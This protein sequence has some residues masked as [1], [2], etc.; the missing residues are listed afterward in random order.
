MASKANCGSESSFLHVLFHRPSALYMRIGGL[1]RHKDCGL[2]C[3]GRQECMC[4]P[5]HAYESVRECVKKQ[6]EEVTN[7]GTCLAWRVAL[8]QRQGE[9]GRGVGCGQQGTWCASAGPP[10]APASALDPDQARAGATH[11]PALHHIRQSVRHST[12]QICST[13]MVLGRSLGIWF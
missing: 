10:P 7:K 3:V 6:Q 9:Q 5:V 13:A 8:H 11:C 12:M 1:S 4:I 2:Q